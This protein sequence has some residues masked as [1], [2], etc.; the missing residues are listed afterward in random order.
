M[1]STQS[2][3]QSPER[4]GTKL[5]QSMRQ[6]KTVVT[7]QEDRSIF[8][9]QM[10]SMPSKKFRESTALGVIIALSALNSPSV[11]L[12]RDHRSTA[13]EDIQISTSQTAHTE[14]ATEMLSYLDLHHGWDGIGSLAPE[15][16]VIVSALRF[17]MQ[18]PADAKSPSATV[19]VD[20][21]V[22]W[23]WREP[24]CFIS[25]L[26]LQNKQFAYYARLHNKELLGNSIQFKGTIPA[27]LL[28]VIL[29]V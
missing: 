28:R 14:A 16:E 10:Y 25:V 1:L 2:T 5:G 7:E 6:P 21:E 23:Y 18:V 27:D 20:G 9:R 3:S 4:R 24:D 12:G 15:S 8:G 26:F 19:S 22:G 29:A 13:I 11:S 17:L